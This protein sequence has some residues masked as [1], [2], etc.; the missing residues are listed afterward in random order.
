MARLSGWDIVTDQIPTQG[1]SD[2]F[3][4]IEVMGALSIGMFMLVGLTSMIDTSL[5]EARA[6]Q[7]GRYQAQ[8]S[9]AAA[10]YLADQ[11]TS[12][13][14]ETSVAPKAIS[15]IKLQTTIQPA[16][17]DAYLPGSFGA[18]NAFDQKPCMLVM[19]SPV[20]GSTQLDALIVTEGGI[21]I[22]EQD[23]AYAAANAGPNGG[24][25]RHRPGPTPSNP[26]GGPI[27]AEGAYGSWFL[28]NL[29]LGQFL[30]ASCTTSA[31]AGN[32]A[33]GIFIGGA[34]AP[35]SDF[36]YRKP[37]NGQPQLNSMTTPLGM[38]NAALVATGAPC[39]QLATMAMDAISN[40]LVVCDGNGRWVNAT[41]SSWK[42]PVNAYSD[43]QALTEDQPGDVRITI[44]T[45]RAFVMGPS[46]NWIPLALD[47]NGNMAV[48]ATLTA[49]SLVAQA[50]PGTAGTITA[51]GNVTGLDVKAMRDLYAVTGNAWVSKEVHAHDTF[52]TNYSE[53]A[54]LSLN[55]PLPAGFA[56]NYTVIDPTTGLPKL[57]YPAGS[58]VAGVNGFTMFCRPDSTAPG[59]PTSG[60]YVYE[61][62][63]TTPPP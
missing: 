18:A 56:C 29:R 59:A 45:G 9:A 13:W 30:A 47:Q 51:S 7:A 62:G 43:L 32:L 20:A 57:V 37:I 61:N 15:L 25:V 42:T 60:H 41:A 1:R 10:R 14:A 38:R 28:D 39:A 5:G 24:V 55:T 34:G 16:S 44:D 36:L 17:V 58:L 8:F 21:P 26:L 35:G 4:L 11:Y 3:T 49:G 33:S 2:G 50:G 23:L 27:V 40:R 31:R 52:T 12:L 22:P 46:L 63:T 48:P 54:L 53:S 19:R 6:Q